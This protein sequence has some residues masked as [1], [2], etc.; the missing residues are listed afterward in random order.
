MQLKGQKTEIG[1]LIRFHEMKI[2][3]EPRGIKT[4]VDSRGVVPTRFPLNAGGESSR[5]HGCTCEGK[6]L[7][8]RSRPTPS[9]SVS[10]G[11]GGHRYSRCGLHSPKLYKYIL[12]IPIGNIQ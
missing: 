1:R 3:S 5:K 6:N 8:A 7:R 10:M 9:S 4:S 2:K 12:S 11:F